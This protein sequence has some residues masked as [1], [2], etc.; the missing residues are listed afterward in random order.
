M[1]GTGGLMTGSVGGVRVEPVNGE[2][3]GRADLRSRGVG[4]SEA[5]EL[6]ARLTSFAE[7]WESPEM[8]CDDN[9]DAAKGK[10]HLPE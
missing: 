4:P 5:A 9:Y 3:S 7:D 6:R 1:E 2:Q 10:I 8:D